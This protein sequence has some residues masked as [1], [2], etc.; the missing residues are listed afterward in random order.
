MPFK[1]LSFQFSHECNTFSRT[2]TGRAAFEE[3]VF[4]EGSE[5]VRARFTDTRTELGAHIDAAKAY[6]WTLAQPFAAHATPSGRVTR[7]MLAYAIGHACRAAKGA[8]AALLALHGAMVGQDADDAEGHLLE[9]LR[10]ELG[11]DKPIVITLD[12]H[13]NVTRRMADNANAIIAFRTY[14]HVD[15]YEVA[16]EGAK[17]LERMLRTGKRTS[18]YLYK[19]P[20]L[21]GCDHGRTHGSGPMPRLL[22]LAEDIRRQHPDLGLDVISITPGFP[23]SDIAEA[24]PA[25]TVT[26]TA[27]RADVSRAVAPLME[28][29]WRTRDERSIQL[30]S[31]NEMVQAVR[32]AA[33]EGPIVVSDFSDNP[34]HGAPGDGVAIVK[35]LVDEGIQDAAVACICDPEAVAKCHAAGIGSTLELEFGARIYPEIYGGPMLARV[36]VVKLGEGT[37]THLGPMRKGMKMNLGPTATIAIDGVQVVLATH[38]LQVADLAYFYANGIDP[39]KQ[40]VLVVKSQQHFRGAFEPIAQQVLLADSG[41][42][43]SPNLLKLPYQTVRRPIYPLDKDVKPESIC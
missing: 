3:R 28:E 16:T 32:A 9:S 10:R 6:G 8:D 4:V 33:G 11:E 20:L 24:G 22:R 14:P 5:A 15:Q 2:L 34:G 19:P 39:L 36:K 29:I 42:F 12:L 41:G 18:T 37:L 1:I 13:A 43:V 35:A 23:W 27:N 7:E 25:V 40:Q 17:L 30:L 26:T 31:L 38:N 21:D